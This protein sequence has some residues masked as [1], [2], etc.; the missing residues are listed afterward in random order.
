MADARCDYLVTVEMKGT[1]SGFVNG[2]FY[3]FDI[4][5]PG[6]IGWRP[7]LEA[8]DTRSMDDFPELSGNPGNIKLSYFLQSLRLLVLGERKV[9]L[10]QKPRPPS[11]RR[12]HL[13]TL[14]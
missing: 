2:F 12:G 9:P 3:L 1:A 13:T 11:G 7:D 4:R 14:R 6:N 5:K 8:L 10:P